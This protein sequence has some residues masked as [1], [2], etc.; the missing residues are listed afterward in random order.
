[1]IEII[2]KRK[3]I[4]IERHIDRERIVRPRI[5]MKTKV[6]EAD[7]KHSERINY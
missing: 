7:R 4:P 5:T 6:G 1:M 3:K 2:P